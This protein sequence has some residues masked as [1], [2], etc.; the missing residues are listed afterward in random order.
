VFF[1]FELGGWLSHRAAVQFSE[2]SDSHKGDEGFAVHHSHPSPKLR[3]PHAWAL[4]VYATLPGDNQ[5]HSNLRPV[6]IVSCRTDSH[7]GR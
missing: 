5:L 7:Q 6:S 2:A 1:T 4:P 3:R